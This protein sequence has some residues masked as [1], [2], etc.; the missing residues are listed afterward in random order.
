[1]PFDKEIPVPGNGLETWRELDREMLPHGAAWFPVRRCF[2]AECSAV[3]GK[4][5]ETT[6]GP[7][8]DRQGRGTSPLSPGPANDLEGLSRPLHVLPLGE[9]AGI[10]VADEVRTG[11]RT[12]LPGGASDKTKHTQKADGRDER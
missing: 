12:A 9:V 11:R 5:T 6:G 2:Q 8:P 3:G 7:R 4:A 10:E 1:V